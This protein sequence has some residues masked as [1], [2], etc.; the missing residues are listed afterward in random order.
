MTAPNPPVCGFC[1]GQ[2]VGDAAT[3][4]DGKSR[5]PLPCPRCGELNEPKPEKEQ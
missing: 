2:P 1:K 3:W 4:L 5:P